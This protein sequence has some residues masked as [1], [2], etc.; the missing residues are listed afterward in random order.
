MKIFQSFIIKAFGMVPLLG[1]ILFGCEDDKKKSLEVPKAAATVAAEAA[2]SNVIPKAPLNFTASE[3]TATSVKLAWD[4]VEGEQFYVVERCAGSACNNFSDAMLLKKGTKEVFVTGLTSG[5]QYVFSIYGSG[6]DTRAG[7][8]ATTTATT[9]EVS[10][11]PTPV[12]GPVPQAPSQLTAVN[13][14]NNSVALQWVDNADNEALYQIESCLGLGCTSFAPLENSPVLG[15][16]TTLNVTE[17]APDTNVSFRVRAWNETGPSSWAVLANVQI[18]AQPHLSFSA[19]AATQDS[20]TLSWGN[21]VGVSSTTQ[22]ERCKVNNTTGACAYIAL[23]ESPFANGVSGFIDNPVLAASTY[24]YRIRRNIGTNFSTWL[25]SSD[26]KTLSLSP[27]GFSAVVSSNSTVTLNWFDPNTAVGDI[28]SLQGA[29]YSGGT[30]GTFANLT[31]ASGGTNPTAADAQTASIVDLQTSDKWCFRIRNEVNSAPSA[32]ATIQNI[33]MNPAAPVNPVVSQLT[34]TTTNFGWTDPATSTG[35]IF[36]VEHAPYTAGTCGAFTLSTL[37]G[38]ANP[39]APDSSSVIITGLSNVSPGNFC[40]RVRNESLG[41]NSAYAQLSNVPMLLPAPVQLASTSGEV[42]DVTLSLRWTRIP[43]ASGY[44][45]E[46]CVGASCSTAFVSL[47]TVAQV[48]TGGVVFGDAGLTSNTSYGYRIKALR[49]LGTTSGAGDSLNIAVTTT[50]TATVPATP[51]TLTGTSISSSSVTLNWPDAFTDVVFYQIERCDGICSA[52][53]GA[54]SPVVES[55]VGPTGGPGIIKVVPL[56]LPLPNT[57]YTFRVRALGLAGPSEYVYSAPVTSL[58]PSATALASTAI[59]A[60]NVRL[61]WTTTVA[62]GSLELQSCIGASCSNFAQALP[63]ASEVAISAPGSLQYT[64]AGQLPN[65]VYNYRGRIKVTSP[66]ANSSDWFTFPSVTT[67]VIAPTSA[68]INAAAVLSWNANGASPVPVY[69]IESCNAVSCTDTDY[70]AATPAT[71]TSPATSAT[72]TGLTPESSYLFRVRA[73]GTPASPWIYTLSRFTTVPNSPT[74]VGAS[75]SAISATGLTLNWPSVATGSASFLEIAQCPGTCTPAF[76]GQVVVSKSKTA[77]SH[78][79]VG[80]TGNTTYSFAIRAVGVAGDG[81]PSAA[82]TV[83]TSPASPT[84]I[85]L[86]GVPSDTSLQLS[87]STAVASNNDLQLCSGN[88]CTFA[89][90]TDNAAPTIGV[91]ATAPTLLP[92]SAATATYTVS[93]LTPAT[94]YSFR[95]RQRNT[96]ASS[97]WVTSGSVTNVLTAATPVSCTTPQQAIIDAGQKGNVATLQR[98]TIS[99]TKMIPGT[100][101]PAVA[102]WDTGTATIKYAWWNGSQFIVESVAGGAAASPNQAQQ[103]PTSITLN[104]L[105][106]KNNSSG[107]TIDVPANARRPMIFWTGGAIAG[108]SFVRGA[109]RSTES[110]SAGTWAVATTMDTNSALVAPRAIDSAVSPTD[111]VLVGFLTDTATSGKPRVL[112]CEAGCSALSSFSTPVSTEVVDS[113]LITAAQ[114][115]TGVAFCPATA[116]GNIYLPAM[117]YGAGT[118]TKYAVCNAGTTTAA[119]IG[120]CSSNGGTANTK[121]GS[122]AVIGTTAVGTTDLYIDETTLGGSAKILAKPAATTAAIHTTAAGCDITPVAVATSGGSITGTLPGS[123]FG[124]LM[125]DSG[126]RYHVVVNEGTTSVL[127]YNSVAAGST[128]LNAAGTVETI[129]LSAVITGGSDIN[130][131]NQIYTSYG[132]AAPAP[133]GDLVVGVVGDSSLPSNSTSAVN[134][135]LLPD[136]YG[137][138]ALNTVAGGQIRNVSTAATSEGYFGSVHID[139]STGSVSGARLKYSYRAGTTSATRWRSVFIPSTQAPQ[140]PSL[141]F[142]S[143]NKPWISYYDSTA[144]KYYALSNSESDGTGTW[145]KYQFP[146]ITNAAATFPAIHDT[147]MTMHYSS[148]VGLPVM[149]IMNSSATGTAGVKASRLTP[150]TGTWSTVRTLDTMGASFGSRLVADFDTNGKIAVA[151]YDITTTTVKYNYSTQGTVWAASATSITAANAA[152]EGL[153][154][155]FNPS[156]GLPAISYINRLAGTLKGSL[157]FSSCAGTFA[158]CATLGNWTASVGVAE[159]GSGLGLAVANIP[160]VQEQLLQTV[161]TFNSSGIPSIAHINN[162]LAPVQNLNLITG[163]SATSV[164]GGTTATLHSVPYAEPT[165]GTTPMLFSGAATGFS[166]SGVRNNLGQLLTAYIGPNNWLYSTTCE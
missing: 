90:A 49:N 25:T 35:D 136:T 75:I 14:T 157:N 97:A 110:A 79:I 57:T 53:V 34:S 26:V 39:T 164:A 100:N 123:L 85:S 19:G 72:M 32:Y 38:S 140:A 40:F 12:A 7:D 148:G 89:V 120:T 20:I 146:Q 16:T 154:I 69:D 56:P 50:A 61:N 83:T 59:D 138:V 143:S 158:G 125:R 5:T 84:S 47:G 65:T 29:P 30:C 162:S 104:F 105:R 15:N 122:F 108:G 156:S 96:T 128:T 165:L 112:T 129:A 102:Y 66:S 42:K 17:L 127:Y 67:P 113:A 43:E 134:Y 73:Q 51:A 133:G 28:F 63:G 11:E 4:D 31:V 117:V 151:F 22:V 77:T 64:L 150:A 45:V 8:P 141:A 145:T 3:V 82:V 101:S 149:I 107:T 144:L 118:T 153:N 21:V 41:I 76:P 9:I 1:I 62:L 115:Q 80:L 103:T 119:S 131:A 88:N 55:P 68:V 98:G 58:V 70:V 36:R 18:L 130:S 135:S 37:S 2:N 152:R 10:T 81:V 48:A 6:N 54:F 111:Q 52:L 60:T 106:G 155:R 114:P 78:A 116:G 109:M 161:L 137:N 95:I 71:T 142:D 27:L 24:R 93:S 147:A 132:S 124:T 86:V 126:D 166:A 160:V 139:Y 91:A 159:S 13:V 121:W 46:R 92:A 23:A 87:I 94:R 163:L 44:Q 74:L 33:V 99:S